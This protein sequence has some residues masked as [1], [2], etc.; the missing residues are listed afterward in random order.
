MK[1]LYSLLLA[2]SLVFGLSTIAKAQPPD[3]WTQISSPSIK[4]DTPKDAVSMF[5]GSFT[6]TRSTVIAE[7]VEN[8][9]PDSQVLKSFVKEIHA[10][11]ADFHFFVSDI[12]ITAVSQNPNL[13]TAN[14]N[15]VL[16]DDMGH[17]IKQDDSITLRKHT[18]QNGDYWLLVPGNPKD[19]QDKFYAYK[20][21]DNKSHF[22]LLLATELV[23][24]AQ[25]QAQYHLHESVSQLNQILLGAILYAQKHKWQLDFDASQYKK[26]LLPYIKPDSLFTAPGDPDG[27]VSYSMNPNIRGINL[28]NF[29]DTKEAHSL[30]V[31]YL[32]HDQKLDFKYDGYAT[33]AFMDGVVRKVSRE[34][35]KDIRWKP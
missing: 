7:L 21:P 31:I 27:T 24:P 29:K 13:V 5:L 33:V 10:S 15:I 35:A 25:M 14:F 6:F 23:Y 26:V 18:S 19:F 3:P 16:I 30:V 1:K 17:W 12:K 9:N 22:T 11:L 4:A 20:N 32:G 2:G 28:E 8:A 34:Q